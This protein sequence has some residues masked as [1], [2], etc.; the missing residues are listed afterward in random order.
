MGK[1]F[2]SLLSRDAR[3]WPS[4]DQNE[5]PRYI[6]AKGNNG[7]TTPPRR[8][9]SDKL[10]HLVDDAKRAGDASVAAQILS[11]LEGTRQRTRDQIEWE[12]R[13]PEAPQ[14]VPEQP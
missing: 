10:D 14:K 11:L 1:Q 5:V 13:I 4:G 7:P 12:R 2:S 8:R 6:S 3:F 9:L